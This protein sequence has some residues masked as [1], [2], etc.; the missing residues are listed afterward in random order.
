M[1][2]KISESQDFKDALGYGYT[3]SVDE[4]S[5]VGVPGRSE[6]LNL[7]VKLISGVMELSWFFARDNRWGQ[8]RMACAF[9]A[10]SRRGDD[11]V[12]TRGEAHGL[13]LFVRMQ[14]TD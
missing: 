9:D 3:P 2:A 4:D 10:C 11:T 6:E 7:L 13:G 14:G 12:R 5:R 8:V 1:P